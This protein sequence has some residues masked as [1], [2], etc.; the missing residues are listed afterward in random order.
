MM[1]ASATGDYPDWMKQ[2]LA[3]PVVDAARAL[4]ARI[5]KE[6]GASTSLG[7]CPSCHQLRRHTKSNDKRGAVSVMRKR[8][9]RWHCFQCDFSG[10]T[11]DFI[12]LATVDR[13]YAASM[14]G[15]D[16]ALVREAVERLVGHRPPSSVP[17]AV[18][19][20]HDWFPDDEVARLW[21]SARSV[22]DDPGCRAW[23]T[24]RNIDPD[25][26]AHC[27]L[28]GALVPGTP[29]PKWAGYS[30]DGRVRSWPEEGLRLVVPLFDATGV[31]R[32]FT[33]RDIA[34][35]ERRGKTWPPKSAAPKRAGLVHACP[36]AQQV[37][38]GSSLP[39]W[40]DDGSP[41]TVVITEGEVD[42]LTWCSE[43]MDGDAYSPAII[44]VGSGSWTAD[45]AARIPA[46]STVVIATDQDEQGDR[47]AD[48]IMKSFRPWTGRVRLKRW[49]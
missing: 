8:P 21:N 36:L 43:A 44:G 35:G 14:S 4:N 46:E 29:L 20:E 27:R 25:W 40:W 15:A 39:K 19:P 30:R 26:I 23:L 49:E 48:R 18:E 38:S 6:G 13:P 31:M 2:T 37:L 42:F 22:A 28:A 33:F 17:P 34:V 16:K 9:S 32:S 10:S 5:F 3:T 47:Y 12:A 7:P 45:F 41:L 24:S 11:L 1:G